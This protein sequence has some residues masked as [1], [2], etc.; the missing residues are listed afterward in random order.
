MKRLIFTL[1]TLSLLSTTIQSQNH[2]CGTV[3]AE[4]ELHKLYPELGTDEDFEKWLAPKIKEYKS[5]KHL[6][7]R[8][9]TTLPIIFHIIHNGE[10]VGVGDNI[11]KRL[12]DAQIDQLNIDFTNR[13]G[14]VV[15][16]ATDLELNFCPASIDP[17][18]NYLEEPGINRISRSTLGLPTSSSFTRTT[19]QTM[20]KPQT[21]WNPND[22]INIWVMPMTGGLIGYAQFPNYPSM[23]GLGTDLSSTTRAATLIASTDGVAMIPRAIGSTA[24][25]NPRGG[26]WEQVLT[27]ELGHFLGLRHTSGDPSAGSSAIQRC[28]ADDFVNDT[29]RIGRQ[30]RICSPTNQCND[31]NFGSL[32]DPFDMIT[33][34]MDY[35][36]PCYTTFTPD[37]SN[38]VQTI[39]ENAPRR[40]ELLN[41]TA[42]ETP[43]TVNF[44]DIFPCAIT[45]FINFPGIGTVFDIC[46]PS[47]SIIL[48][49]FVGVYLS[50]KLS[51][52][53]LQHYLGEIQIPV[54]NPGETLQGFQW[55]AD[56][57]Q[58]PEIPSGDYLIV[59]VAD[60]KNSII[61]S[62]ET[63]NTFAA[64]GTINIQGYGCEN[65]V[66]LT[67][68]TSQIFKH[69]S[70]IHPNYW[71]DYPCSTFNESGNERLFKFTTTQAG[72]ININVS[73]SGQS[74]SWAYLLDYC[75]PSSC[76]DDGSSITTNLPAGT[77]YIVIEEYQTIDS[78]FT[79]TLDCI[80]TPLPCVTDITLGCN[81]VLSFNMSNFVVDRVNN[82]TCIDL[83]NSSDELAGVYAG[84]E[85]I[86]SISIFETSDI[87]MTVHGEGMVAFLLDNCVDANCLAYTTDGESIFY[88]Q[89]A[90]GNY[91]ITVEQTDIANDDYELLIVCDYPN[92]AYC[93]D[94]LNLH[95][96]PIPSGVYS[97]NTSI[98]GNTALSPNADV[99][100]HAGSEI[101]FQPNYDSVLPST[102]LNAYIEG[103]PIS[104]NIQTAS[105]QA[106]SQ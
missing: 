45:P 95:N 22:Y 70:F 92:S 25:R 68:G 86:H 58:F 94:I 34:Y 54:I 89:L 32:T 43:P 93:P 26:L 59:L 83:T 42:C 99:T 11:S 40:K 46:N 77:Y 73:S 51:D 33:N 28:Q 31:M 82:Y 65:V 47:A 18:G 35:V 36:F 8:A 62:N 24:I 38:R 29:P 48:P 3:E 7:I 78:E 64:T 60:H 56:L 39:L 55:S 30:N 96:G 69:D 14:S 66:E 16:I 97:A 20:I 44:P 98:N 61:E 2:F 13:A 21:Q 63:N 57:G 67:C 76:I 74:A 12:V 4:K 49:S 88:P 19:I 75:N 84:P 102:I 101:N 53:L 23:G 79:I 1:I 15:S 106:K 103:C 105:D 72:D 6:K 5:Q 9:L 100:M 71:E 50:P 85:A 104:P 81:Q 37:Q 41:S 27:H 80:D 52:P 10:A 17:S 91:I 90:P 87:V